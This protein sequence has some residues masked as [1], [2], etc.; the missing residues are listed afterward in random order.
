MN[1]NSKNVRK[2]TLGGLLLALSV[3]TSFLEGAAVANVMLPPGV[4]LGV[5]NIITMYCLFFLG[6]KSAL[7]LLILK[8][9]FALMTRG[10]IAGCLSLMGGLFAIFAMES[11]NRLFK[12]MDK[13]Y[14]SIAGGVFHNLG[15]LLGAFVLL[16]NPYVIYY[17]PVLFV[18]GI[19]SGTVTGVSL[20]LIMP[21]FNKISGHFNI[22]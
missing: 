12:D 7:V 19:I 14:I 4:R 22:K 2:I 6:F 18:F 20:R 15:Q 11:L 8:S 3:S 10:V 1:N 9:I 13:T 17:L 16:H 21:Y 5:S